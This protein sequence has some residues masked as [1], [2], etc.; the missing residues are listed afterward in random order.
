MDCAACEIVKKNK[1]ENSE[2][3]VGHYGSADDTTMLKSC[4]AF[5]NVVATKEH[6]E[7][8]FGFHAAGILADYY[9]E[10]RLKN[11][12]GSPPEILDYAIPCSLQESKALGEGYYYLSCIYKYKYN[13]N[14]SNTRKTNIIHITFVLNIYRNE[15]ANEASGDCPKV[16]SAVRTSL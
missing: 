13:R 14:I 2:R 10:N 8:A 12:L 15:R 9:S 11:N 1:I 6:E 3:K 5:N 16:Q 4:R 7:A